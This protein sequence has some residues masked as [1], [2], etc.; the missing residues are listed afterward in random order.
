MSKIDL[1]N[2][3]P[4]TENVFNGSG[5]FEPFS[6]EISGNILYVADE[7][8]IHQISI[9][10]TTATLIDV[11]INNNYFLNFMELNG[12]V[13]YTSVGQ[14]SKIFKL[15]I[16]NAQLITSEEIYSGASEVAGMHLYNNELYFVTGN[17]VSRIDDITATNITITDVVTGLNNPRNIIIIDNYLYINENGTEITKLSL[18]TLG[19]EDIKNKIDFKL[20]P[21]PTNKDVQI[22]GNIYNV[23]EYK[24][25]NI[26]GSFVFL[27]KLI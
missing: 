5:L 6:I 9:G 7:D 11:D 18:S 26:S 4:T 8:G 20:Y 24:I 16:S 17:K 2:S 27:I 1:T 15:D 10:Q 21:N 25:F 12:D 3:S 19:V 23:R 13:I 14:G 22:I